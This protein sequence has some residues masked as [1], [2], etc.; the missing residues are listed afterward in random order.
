MNELSP[1]PLSTPPFSLCPSTLPPLCFGNKDYYR[2]EIARGNHNGSEYV[3]Q[4]VNEEEKNSFGN[5]AG[6]DTGGREERYSVWGGGGGRIITM[7]TL[8]YRMQ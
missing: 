1:P 4:P 8:C 5:T 3:T 7:R 6:K 2:R